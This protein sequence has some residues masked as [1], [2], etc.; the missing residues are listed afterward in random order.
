MPG[1]AK[2]GRWV[3]LAA[4][5]AS[6]ASSLLTPSALWAPTP[7][8]PTAP[9]A[10]APCAACAVAPAAPG[11]AQ[12][13]TPRPIWTLRRSIAQP[14]THAP[15]RSFSPRS[16]TWASPKTAGWRPLA[17]VN[18]A[19]HVGLEGFDHSMLSRHAANPLVR[20]DAHWRR[21]QA[22]TAKKKERIIRSFDRG[23]TTRFR[24]SG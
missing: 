2:A 10:S 19:H 7:S 13:P 5:A 15:A 17:T 20:F 1:T 24:C 22:G 18:L 16:T 14:S 23:S 21:L 11:T 3:R 8:T 12:T 6:I 9:A 4:K